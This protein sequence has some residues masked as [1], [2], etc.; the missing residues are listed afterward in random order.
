MKD[1]QVRQ[2]IKTTLKD[3]RIVELIPYSRNA[4]EILML[5]SAVE[6]NL[7]EY[8]YQVEGPAQGI[9]QMEPGT[10]R[11]IWLNYIEYKP[12][13]KKVV[14]SFL[15]DGQNNLAHNLE[16]QVLMAR[17]HYRRVSAPLPDHK[18]VPAMA[19]YWKK[20]YNTHLGKGTVE[21][22]RAKYNRYVLD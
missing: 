9:F 16:Y 3:P 13:L 1:W 2:L 4:E 11:D 7:G 15:N 18:N 14:E 22:A 8:I 17:L 12:A 10:E 6:S 19:E 21:H 5:T 20:Y